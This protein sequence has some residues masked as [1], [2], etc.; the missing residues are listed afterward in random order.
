VPPSLAE[1]CYFVRRN[2]TFEQLMHRFAIKFANEPSFEAF[3]AAC[4][5]VFAANAL[6]CFQSIAFDKTQACARPNVVFSNIETPLRPAA[7]LGL[8]YWWSISSCDVC[9]VC[10][11]LFATSNGAALRAVQ[12]QSPPGQ[13]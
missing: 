8:F 11:S 10:A 3:L 6:I 4:R 12:N 2:Q 9:S 13:Q 7:N 5:E 1:K